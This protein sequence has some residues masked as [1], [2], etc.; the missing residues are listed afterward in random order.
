MTDVYRDDAGI[1]HCGG[2]PRA[3]IDA[4]RKERQIEV[5]RKSMKDAENEFIDEHPLAF[6]VFI[7]VGIAGMCALVFDWI[8]IGIVGWLLLFLF[9]VVGGVIRFAL[10]LLDALV[11]YL[12]E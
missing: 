6:L 4:A 12:R 2:G 10:G 9:V 3:R 5:K 1:H 7:G 11:D 8:E